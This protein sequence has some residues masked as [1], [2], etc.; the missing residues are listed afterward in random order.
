MNHCYQYEIDHPE[1]KS[2]KK[3][4]LIINNERK[5]QP[6]ERD[7]I[8]ED[9]HELACMNNVLVITTPVFL[10]MFDRFIGG[11]IDREYCSNLIRNNS[12]VLKI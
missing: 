12:G 8:H 9:V 5:R 7:E 6:A 1:S 2:I 10:I 11:K 4:V 3:P